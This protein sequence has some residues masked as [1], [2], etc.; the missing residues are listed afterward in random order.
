MQCQYL[1]EEERLLICSFVKPSQRNREVFTLKIEKLERTRQLAL[2]ILKTVLG[3]RVIASL[4]KAELGS[5]N[6]GPLSLHQRELSVLIGETLAYAYAHTHA[7]F[8][9]CSPK[10]SNLHHSNDDARSLTWRVTRELQRELPYFFIN[11]VTSI[12]SHSMEIHFF[13]WALI[14]HS[15]YLGYS[16]VTPCLV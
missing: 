2:N 13:L 5:L 4:Q 9:P 3:K 16:Q 11:A 12:L 1:E 14:T 7:I 10:G 6:C 8:P 15:S